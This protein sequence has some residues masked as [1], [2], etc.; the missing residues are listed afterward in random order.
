[1]PLRVWIDGQHQVRKVAMRMAFRNV[2]MS[3]TVNITS[4]N[5][6]VRIVPPP[7]SQ[8]SVLSHP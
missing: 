7:S 4:I 2:S 3:F 1:M 5:R 6:P 8:V